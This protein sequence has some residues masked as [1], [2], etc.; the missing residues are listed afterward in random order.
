MD[1]NNNILNPN[2]LSER[3]RKILAFIERFDR[4]NGYPPT[5]R[6]IG[7]EVKISSTSVVSYNLKKLV[8]EGFLERE[9]KVSRGVRLSRE[10]QVRFA[11][12]E[13]LRHVPQLGTITAGIALEVPAGDITLVDEDDIIEVPQSMIGDTDDVFA[14]RVDGFSMVDAMVNDGDVVVLKRQET[15]RN[16][17][18]VAV[19]L[20]DRGETTLKR[21]YYEG[22]KVRL[23]P[24]NPYMDP[25]IVDA[26]NVQVQGRVL[27]VLRTL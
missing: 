15:A 13:G 17:E 4:E 19:L 22:S 18:M 7:R 14:L 8:K 6:D 25:I 24:A 23:Q 10:Y 3:Q 26:S 21:I 16:G 27:A 11:P 9:D 2:K 12:P 1:S 20:K 5:V